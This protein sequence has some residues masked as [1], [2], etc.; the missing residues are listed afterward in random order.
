GEAG[1]DRKE[2]AV[3]VLEVDRLDAERAAV[4]AAGRHVVGF[5]SEPDRVLVCSAAC[6]EP[7]EGRDACAAS[8]GTFLLDGKL[9]SE[10][11]PSLTGRF[12]LGVKRR[13][14]ALLGAALGLLLALVGVLAILRGL[15]IR[16]HPSG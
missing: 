9:A 16:P 13:P 5:L 11:S 14:A 3:R 8:L 7:A 2:G 10:P 6:V 4:T 12:V 15:M 1:G